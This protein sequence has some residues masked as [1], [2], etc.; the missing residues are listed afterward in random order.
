MSSLEAT[1]CSTPLFIMSEWQG[2]GRYTPLSRGLRPVLFTVPKRV[3][4][5]GLSAYPVPDLHAG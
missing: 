4:L 1:V 5:G 2:M 3:E